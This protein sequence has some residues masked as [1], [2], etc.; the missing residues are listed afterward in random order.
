LE[1]TDSKRIPKFEVHLK[2]IKIG[3]WI[4]T[5]KPKYMYKLHK[6]IGPKRMPK[7]HRRR[8]WFWEQR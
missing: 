6:M 4:G 8:R 5:K 1:A 3:Q 2:M 7:Q